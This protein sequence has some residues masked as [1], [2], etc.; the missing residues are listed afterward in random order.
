MSLNSV[1]QLL[2]SRSTKDFGS[3]FFGNGCDPWRLFCLDFYSATTTSKPTKHHTSGR[4]VNCPEVVHL[5]KWMRHDLSMMLVAVGVSIVP[6]GEGEW[7]ARL[8]AALSAI[9]SSRYFGLL[10]WKLLTWW[11]CQTLPDTRESLGRLWSKLR[12]EFPPTK[13]CPF[14]SKFVGPT[15]AFT[16]CR[17]AIG[18]ASCHLLIMPRVGR[19]QLH[20]HIQEVIKVLT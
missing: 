6:I 16:R 5:V 11:L 3:Q 17:W 9:F 15:S 14:W 19:P 2:R 12:L 1:V 7:F 13:I 18:S 8:Q 20:N 10:G 4:V